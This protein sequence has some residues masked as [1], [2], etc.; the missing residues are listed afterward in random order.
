MGD[1]TMKSP[2][3]RHDISKYQETQHLIKTKLYI[4]WET[5]L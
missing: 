2:I 4:L 1:K 3:I 5:K